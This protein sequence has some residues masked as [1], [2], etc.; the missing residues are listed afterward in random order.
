M[1]WEWSSSYF[2]GSVNATTGEQPVENWTMTADVGFGGVTP[3]AS[4]ALDLGH[5][6]PTPLEDFRLTPVDIEPPEYLL[7]VFLGHDWRT[8]TASTYSRTYPS[9]TRR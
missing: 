9:T 1:N 5:T 4:L 8:V 2:E 7:P 3:T 6:Q